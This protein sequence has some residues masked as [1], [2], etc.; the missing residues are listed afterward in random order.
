MKMASGRVGLLIALAGV[1][2]AGAFVALAQDFKGFRSASSRSALPTVSPS[3]PGTSTPQDYNDAGRAFLRWWNPLR[4]VRTNLDNDQSFPPIGTLPGGTTVE[5]PAASW[6][7][8]VGLN[9][10]V[11]ALNYFQAS[12]VGE[13][14]RLTKTVAQTTGSNDPRSGATRTYRWTFTDL[15]PGQ[16]YRLSL[17]IPLGPTRAAGGAITAGDYP[18]RYYVADVTGDVAGTDVEVIDTFSL[19]GGFVRLGNEGNPTEKVYIAGASGTLSVN[20]Y[21]T[22]PRNSQGVFL[23]PD[24]LPG[25]QWVYADAVR[26]EQSFAT[27][28][29]MTSQPIVAELDGDT[30]PSPGPFK[31]RTIAARNEGLSSG[32]LARQ[33][34][35][36]TVTNYSYGGALA[37]LAQPGRLN[38]AWSWPVPRPFNNGASESTRYS[39]ERENWIHGPVAGNERHTFRSMQDN[40]FSQV[41]LAGFGFVSSIDPQSPGFLGGDY[42][43]G[44]SVSGTDGSSATGEVRYQ[45]NVPNGSY[46]VQVY[47]PTGNVRPNMA[48]RA[49]VEVYLGPTLVDTL[50]VDQRNTGWVS[51]IGQPEDGYEQ[52]TASGPLTLR[53]TNVAVGGVGQA[54]IADGVRWLADADLSVTST[55]VFETTD[56]AVST[57]T[58][59]DRDVVIVPMEDGR[60]YALDAVGDSSTG[61]APTVYW[62]YPS[63]NPS[64][65]PNSALTQDGRSTELPTGFNNSSG[66]IETVGGDSIFYIASENGRIYALDVEGRGD[67]TTERIWSWPNDYDPTNPVAARQAPQSG[68]ASSVTFGSFNGSPALYVLTGSGWLYVLDAAG[69]PATRTTTVLYSRDLVAEPFTTTP[70]FDSGVLYVNYVERGTSTGRVMAISGTDGSTIWTSAQAFSVFNRSGMVLVPGSQIT[71][72][73]PNAG[74]DAL[75]VGDSSGY[76]ASLDPANGVV[77]WDTTEITSGVSGGIGFTYLSV[78]NNSGTI[79]NLAPSVLIP[80]NGGAL[81]AINADGS[82][83]SQGTRRIWQHNLDRGPATSPATGGWRSSDLFSW[84][85]VGDSGGTLYAF[86]GNDNI[87]PGVITPGDVPGWQEVIENDPDFGDLDG[88]ITSA[89]FEAISPEG[90]EQLNQGLLDDSLTNATVG[91]IASTHGVTRRTFEFGETINLLVHSLPTISSGDYS[92]ELIMSSTQ[93][94]S[95]VRRQV[96][97]RPINSTIGTGP[98]TRLWL[99]SF[100]LLP[101]SN[102]MPPGTINLRARAVANQNR[103][104]TSQEVQLPFTD[105]TPLPTGNIRVSN[106]LA[107]E[108]PRTD[109]LAGLLSSRTGVTTDA[110]DAR[111]IENGSGGVDTGAVPGPR[112]ES[113]PVSD[114]PG[115]YFGPDITTTGDT[116]PHATQGTQRMNIVDR[117]LSFL[118]FGPNRG[119][120]NVRLSGQ[121]MQFQVRFG[122]VMQPARNTYKPLAQNGVSY[123]SFEDL[124]GVFPNRSLDYPD[125]GRSALLAAKTRLSRTENPLYDGVALVPPTASTPDLSAYRTAAGFDSQLVRTLA[126]TPVDVS[127][128]IPRY[129]P[130]SGPASAAPAARPGYRGSA[131]IYLDTNATSPGYDSEDT[132]R[133]V[134]FGLRVAPDERLRVGQP[135]L[136]LGSAPGGAGYN[137]GAPLGGPGGRG[138]AE[139]GS[140]AFSPADS[141]FAS[142]F[143]SFPVFNDGN[144]NLLN[145][146]LGRNERLPSGAVRPFRLSLLGGS[147]MAWLHPARSVVSDLDQIFSPTR[148]LDAGARVF[149]QKAR[150]GDLVPTRLSTNPIRRSNANFGVGSGTLL[151]PLAFQTGDPKVALVLPP[152]SPSG[153]Y[154]GTLYAY[155][156][157]AADNILGSRVI[158]LPVD[159]STRESY[160]DPGLTLSFSVRESRLTNRPTR[161]SPPMIDNLIT[162][163]ENFTWVNS[164]PALAR[165]S[166]GGSLALAFTSNRL[167]ASGL[168]GF[169]ARARAA[170]DTSA[171]N[172]WRIYLASMGRQDPAGLS[173]L[174]GSRIQSQLNFVP[175]SSLNQWFRRETVLPEAAV[176]NPEN[177]FDLPA[178][179]S[180]D[181]STMAF[182]A[183]ALPASG[184]MDALNPAQ[185]ANP[186]TLDRGWTYMAFLGT[187]RAVDGSGNAREA[188]RIFLVRFSLSDSGQVTL[189]PV[190]G[191]TRMVAIPGDPFVRKSAPSLTQSGVSAHVAYT[192]YSGNLGQAMVSTF[193]GTS[194][195][196]PGALRTGGFDSVGAPSSILRLNQQ[197]FAPASQAA[198]L[199]VS[200]PARRRGK[201]NSEIFLAGLTTG[202]SGS[203]ATRNQ[204]FYLNRVD[205]LS[206]D[207]STGVY[208]APG[209]VW[210]TGALDLDYPSGTGV[211]DVLM[212]SSA[213]LNS[214]LNK[215]TAEYD[216][217]TGILTCDTSLGGRAALD[218]QTGSVRFTGAV[219]PASSRL[220][221]RYSPACL[222]I[223]TGADANY[224]SVSMVWDNRFPNVDAGSG[225]PDLVVADELAYWHTSAHGTV[226][227]NDRPRGDRLVMA[228]SRTSGDGTQTARPYL[229]SLRFGVQLSSGVLTSAADANY[230]LVAPGTFLITNWGGTPPGEQFYQIDPIS[231]RVYFLNSA[232]GR[233]VTI[234]YQAVD[235]AGRSLGS[236]T[237]TLAVQILPEIEEVPI[238]IE[239]ASNESGLTLALEHSVAGMPGTRPVGG[240]W[241]AWASTRSGSTDLYFQGL[242]PRFQP[243]PPS[244]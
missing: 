240:F 88:I 224:R 212:Y 162:G 217:G 14:Y 239:Q 123:P 172:Q 77:R 144:V 160:S 20:L 226:G 108:F 17:S 157:E 210:R 71:G 5:L 32:R 76:I 150:P 94:S 201:S 137:G 183:P 105:A 104:L 206:R 4:S 167:E 26:I 184:F 101:N 169:L 140:G 173:P 218:T 117:S 51:P 163:T 110:Y 204:Q 112:P 149:L 203:F 68:Q 55:P 236:R 215:N 43:L 187:A 193:N 122:G 82:L 221:V 67:G 40:T 39:V 191:G 90:L 44:T 84:I 34:N 63:D 159:N 70:L 211:I 228:L 164:Q 243:Q 91:S 202:V 213:G 93:G 120:P 147:S 2:G 48:S 106:P 171:Q 128:Q 158:G 151:D 25:I 21:N 29:G 28:G 87:D 62:T 180:V 99:V 38:A 80:T 83:N 129:Q 196:N 200:F 136:D 56:I 79:V 199:D 238:L 216:A 92:I 176:A 152:G 182:S 230:G 142:H 233:T 153:Q 18:Q 97:V 109:A 198:R 6:S 170:L 126:P 45:S 195:G 37:D 85:Y 7:G 89:N 30:A 33:V 58:T 23:D 192:S 177:F 161:F 141:E 16:G 13:P 111:A 132:N 69:T 15:V 118:I 64:S 232:E 50:E 53:V 81:V 121:D 186:Y 168:P 22:V 103:R 190:N 59:E 86:N 235:S 19:G 241:A 116:V 115:G 113:L 234:Q 131:N 139:P 138:V 31:Q 175:D 148:F 220:Y 124:P 134:V 229:S 127:I 9:L 209:A 143:H 107:V 3:T 166:V 189:D 47:I 12:G 237:E 188:S 219:F 205:E 65:D 231:G 207:N 197:G 72:S 223:G 42:Y 78:P 57:S 60:I 156:D 95:T 125:I 75:F 155:E 10:A 98:N 52:T 227:L 179:W 244:R 130:A 24:A 27:S 49:I 145:V 61:A 102:G 194:F 66:L 119:L 1:V 74:Q 133:R 114:L 46:H 165:R 174:A 54:L 146:R 185:G 178:G 154:R 11:F 181:P 36:A 225:F 214:I 100:P 73:G 35:L 242:M 96:P 135:V 41:S 8:P 222:S 208:W